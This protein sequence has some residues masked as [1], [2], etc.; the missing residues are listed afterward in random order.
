[1]DRRA[2]I[3]AVLLVG[4]VQVLSAGCEEEG[5]RVKAPKGP[6]TVLAPPV[7]AL[8][9][10]D[11]GWA[12]FHS[13]RHLLTVRLPEGRAWRIDDHTTPELRATHEGTQTE[14]TVAVEGAGELVGRAQCEALSRKKGR[15]PTGDLRTLEDHVTVGPEA[16][17]SRVWVAVEIGKKNELVG[18]VFAFGGNIRT[19][20]FFHART[21]VPSAGSEIV[22]SERLAIAK[23]GLFGRL[24]LDPPRTSGEAEVPR[25]PAVAGPKRSGAPG[26]G[27]APGRAPA[28]APSL[29]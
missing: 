26:P 10:A 20:L 25:A 22:L 3:F 16:F 17:D 1:M 13:K 19:C 9:L 8:S 27:L 6:E 29:R 23:T 18:H 4:A 11:A 28:P 21:T 24:M 7:V 2:S 12:P 15:V 5:A 14:L